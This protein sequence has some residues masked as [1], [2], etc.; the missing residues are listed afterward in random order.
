M[1]VVAAGAIVAVAVALILSFSSIAAV[2]GAN[3]TFS[4]T[5]TTPFGLL[6]VLSM[7]LCIAIRSVSSVKEFW[8]LM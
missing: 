7:L 4:T 3:I 2:V 1:V 5:H 8:G 6:P